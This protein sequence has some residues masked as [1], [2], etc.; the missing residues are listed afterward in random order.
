MRINY[1]FSEGEKIALKP[2]QYLPLLG[3]RAREL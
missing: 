1:C 2:L 3:F